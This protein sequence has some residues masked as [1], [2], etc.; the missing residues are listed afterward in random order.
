MEAWPR[1]RSVGVV[2]HDVVGLNRTIVVCCYPVTFGFYPVTKSNCNKV[3]NGLSAVLPKFWLAVSVNTR[4][5]LP[6]IYSDLKYHPISV[7]HPI[8]DTMEHQDARFAKMFTDPRF[9]RFPKKK[10]KVEIDSRFASK[11]CCMATCWYSLCATLV[12]LLLPLRQPGHILVWC[13]FS[14]NSSSRRLD[15]LSNNH[16]FWWGLWQQHSSWPHLSC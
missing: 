1:H 11:S 12:L 6:C 3:F 8:T 2:S 7:F 16:G 13:T 4:H 15:N 5:A 14:S 10:A 9:Q